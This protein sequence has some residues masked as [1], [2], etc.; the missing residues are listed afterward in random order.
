MIFAKLPCHNVVRRDA[1][2]R[3]R[4]IRGH[5]THHGRGYPAAIAVADGRV[6]RED[7][8]RQEELHALA[9][10]ADGAL[11]VLGRLA[12]GDVLELVRGDPSVLLVISMMK[13]NFPFIISGAV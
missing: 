7:P 4:M 9:V 2:E 6:R 3:C 13:H 8:L 11:P 12:P 10:V 5:G 1:D